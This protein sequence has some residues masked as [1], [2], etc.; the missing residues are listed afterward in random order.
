[1]SI[2]KQI[3]LVL[4]TTLLLIFSFSSFG[5][6]L[7]PKERI[8]EPDHIISSELIGRDYQLYISFPKNYSNKDTISYPVL[9]VLDG[10][11]AFSLLKGT[12]FLLGLEDEIEEVIIVGIGSETDIPSWLHNRSYDLTTSLDTTAHGW[13]EA[14]WDLPKGSI[15]T[16][17]ASEFLECIKTE[18]IPFVDKNYKTNTDRGITGHSFGGLFTTYCFINSDGYFTRFGISSPSLW[19]DSEKLLNKASS[20]FIENKTWD[21]PRTK[22]F[23]SVGEKE[24]KSMVPTMVKFSSYLESKNYD[25]I[26]LKWKI[27]YE[28][29]HLSV[30]PSN[31]SRTLTTLYGKK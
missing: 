4:T 21:L 1:M 3:N 10:L 28:E 25:N 19:W 2:S 24:G 18:I 8:T 16:G 22:V 5:Q 7:E 11:Q 29:S 14:A 9:Y 27:F 17:G 12:Q 6:K 26:D 15:K 13:M 23:I 30:W 31:I 20:Q